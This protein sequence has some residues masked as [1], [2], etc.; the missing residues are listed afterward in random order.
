MGWPSLV[1][2]V[3]SPLSSLVFGFTA[4]TILQEITRLPTIFPPRRSS[5]SKCPASAPGATMVQ[6]G[7]PMVCCL[8]KQASGQPKGFGQPSAVWHRID[9]CWGWP[10]AERAG[11]DRAGRFR[12]SFL[13]VPDTQ[14]SQFSLGLG[15]VGKSPFGWFNLS[16]ADGLE[17]GKGSRCREAL[18]V[19][20]D[21]FERPRRLGLNSFPRGPST[22]GRKIPNSWDNHRPAGPSGR[23]RPALTNL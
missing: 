9:N 3:K 17:G 4:A 1:C 7:G 23:C 2:V 12:A 11:A 20:Q 19:N 15:L 14:P 13:I 18:V 5:S 16:P 6:T 8:P 22:R 10:K 21:R